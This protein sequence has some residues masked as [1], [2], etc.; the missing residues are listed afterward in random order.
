MYLRAA[1]MLFNESP[2]NAR[3]GYYISNR[4]GVLFHKSARRNTATQFDDKGRV[5]CHQIIRA[6][7]LE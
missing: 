7:E 6:N 3:A 5:V 1:S 4:A 2:K